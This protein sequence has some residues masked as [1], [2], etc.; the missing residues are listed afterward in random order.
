MSNGNHFIIRKIH[1]LL[2]IIPIGLFLLEHL[3]VNSFAGK[4]PEVFNQ[5]IKFFQELPFLVF[6]EILFIFAPILFHGIYGLWIVVTG[7][8]N[9]L[10]YGYYRNWFYVIQRASGVIALFFV[11]W[12]VYIT[13]LSSALYGTPISFEFMAQQLADPITMAMYVIGLV[14]ATF[15]F[16]NGLWAFLVS[17]GIT[18]GPRSQKVSTWACTGL[19]LVLTAVGLK[20]LAAF[21]G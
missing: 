7:Q 5:K 15:H 10:Q 1:S 13:R 16:A 18:I 11:F 17:W 12:H 6:I 8:S 3:F 14:A 4:G 20:A 9:I 21:A 2:G 19:F